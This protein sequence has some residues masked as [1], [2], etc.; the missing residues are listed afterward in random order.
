MES[1]LGSPYLGKLPYLLLTAATVVVLRR[2][3]VK[4]ENESGNHH[5]IIMMNSMR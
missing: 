3:P 1:I 4:L 2:L 5:G